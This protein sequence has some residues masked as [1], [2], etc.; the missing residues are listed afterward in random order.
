VAANEGAAAAP[1]GLQAWSE[2][3]VF[4]VSPFF[5]LDGTYRFELG[6]PDETCRVRIDLTVGDAPRLKA[7]LSLRRRPLD[8]RTVLG[9]LARYPFNTAA[10]VAA[11]HW[12][13]L[14][15]WW[16]GAPFHAKPPYDPGAAR[17]GVA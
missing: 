17:K 13:A 7:G 16:K 5:S 2:K 9:V 3:K 12:E 8:D 4:H 1:E 14:K 6:V 15:L 11:I 10:V